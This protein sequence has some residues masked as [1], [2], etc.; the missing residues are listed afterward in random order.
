MST[1]RVLDFPTPGG[2]GTL[3]PQALRDQRRWVCWSWR[4]GRKPPVDAAGLPDPRWN[5]PETWLTST[6][7]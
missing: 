7:A 3:I 5:E 2:Q 4:D 6:T 1:A